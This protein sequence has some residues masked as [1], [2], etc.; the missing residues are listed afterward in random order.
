M[1][2]VNPLLQKDIDAIFELAEN[3]VDA[4]IALYQ[5][6]FTKEVWYALDGPIGHPLTN[7]VTSDYIWKK[8]TTLDTV[9]CPGYIAGGAWLNKG[10]ETAGKE[11]TLENWTVQLPVIEHE[12]VENEL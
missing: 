10:F 8:M 3:S 7:K 12:T 4:T 9:K 1:N 6:A 5:L 2:K 11:L